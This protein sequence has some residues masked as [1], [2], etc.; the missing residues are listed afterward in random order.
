M[1][2]VKGKTVSSVM[3]SYCESTSVHGFSYW[4][5]AGTK[6]DKICCA[7]FIILMVLGSVTE[8][9]FWIF[10]V[11]AGFSCA[12]ILV[13]GAIVEWITNPSGSIS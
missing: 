8:K 10:V 5:S 7:P 9:I 11:I 6:Y 2:T 1:P 12:S 3:K 13:A 4:I